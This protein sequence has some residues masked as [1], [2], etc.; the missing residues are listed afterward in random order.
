MLWETFPGLL[1]GEKPFYE[2]GFWKITREQDMRDLQS[3]KRGNRGIEGPKLVFCS[4]SCI[5]FFIVCFFPLFL[6]LSLSSLHLS[7]SSVS[8]SVLLS[9]HPS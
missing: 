8:F 5:F 4:A 6:S 7:P 9:P 1:G 2:G 3:P